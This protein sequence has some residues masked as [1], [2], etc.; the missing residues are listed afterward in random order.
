MNLENGQKK[1]IGIFGGSF[2]PPHYGH[3]IVPFY[4]Y[5]FAKLDEVWMMVSPQNPIKS[6]VKESLE[7]RVELCEILAKSDRWLKVTDIEKNFESTETADTLKSLQE[8][9]PD[10]DFTWIMGAD[11]LADFHNWNHW[12]DII[13]NHQI[14]VLP[15]KNYNDKALNSVAAQYAAHL[16]VE[17]PNDLAGKSRGWTF[18]NVPSFNISS[19]EIADELSSGKR[20][21][22]D[23]PFEIENK[24]LEKGLYGTG[25]TLAPII[26]PGPQP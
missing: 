5:H 10:Y 3:R 11:N 1:R 4:A 21:M 15:R 2:D 7:V 20:Q 26:K 12:Q 16:K 13:D 17:N 24:I 22:R 23:L 19:S 14:I 8:I 25:K 18:L 6:S 9:Y